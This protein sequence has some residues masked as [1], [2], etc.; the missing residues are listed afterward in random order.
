[1]STLIHR[2]AIVACCVISTVAGF[3]RFGGAREGTPT[4]TA[5][6]CVRPNVGPSIVHAVRGVV[7]PMAE[8]QRLYGRVD[9]VVSLD[10]DSRIVGARILRTPAG[11][12]NQSAIEAARA[13]SF[14]TAIVNCRPIAS[15][16]IYSVDF[17]EKITYATAAS[18]ARTISIFADAT[19]TRAPDVAHVEARIFTNDDLATGATAKNDAILETLKERLRA[20]GIADEKI[21]A[22]WSLRPP[23][24][25]AGT[26]PPVRQGY[27]YPADRRIDV[28]V[29]AVSNAGNV[30]AAMSS[31][32][33]VDVLG[34][35]YALN[36]RAS[37]YRAARDIALKDAEASANRAL[38]PQRLNLGKLLRDELAQT[39]DGA[40]RTEFV[41]FSRGL[42][43]TEAPARTIPTMQI[44]AAGTVTYE[45]KT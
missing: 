38:T 19:V 41:V 9:V 33:V 23:T 3:G 14:Q 20:L 36:D 22:T 30:A 24:A 37:A 7:S 44:R 34:I 35:R 32:R 27:L 31:V 29:D 21:S 4:P 11:V 18:G 10:A 25:P 17:P 42:R 6:A 8:Q 1:M 43:G 15:D 16:V 12:L 39:D 2:A 26:P 13:S 40:P 5:P 28:T 45:I